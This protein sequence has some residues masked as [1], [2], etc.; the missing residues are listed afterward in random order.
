MEYR[1]FGNVIVLR[2]QIG[3]DIVEKI[4]EVAKIEKIKLA[5]I[6]GVGATANFTVGFF[7]TKTH[8]YHKENHVGDHE[9]LS[10]VGNITD[11]DGQVYLHLHICCGNDMGQ[12]VGGH[13][14][15][16]IVSATAEIF[17]TTIDGVVGR[18]FDEQSGLNLFDFDVKE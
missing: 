14:N 1:K 12:F 6:S 17:I 2:C 4:T 10:L 3:E 8:I 5:S 9:I 7:E 11:K 15:Q 16:A 18:K 13:L